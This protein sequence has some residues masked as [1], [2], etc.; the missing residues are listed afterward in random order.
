MP[1]DKIKIFTICILLFVF[2][3]FLCESALCKERIHPINKLLMQLYPRKQKLWF[4]WVP[5]IDAI[6]A[7]QLYKAGL[8]FFIHIGDEGGNVP[9]SIH[10][11]ER[12][13]WKV[14]PNLLFKKLNRYKYV[15]LYCN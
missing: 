5:R 15:I 8:A 14:N 7:L 12:L 2:L 10:L 9:G 13:A 3:S 1:N 11:T 4:P 6:S